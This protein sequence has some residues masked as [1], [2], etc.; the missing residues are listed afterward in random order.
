MPSEDGDVIDVGLPFNFLP[1]HR[2]M[3]R[4]MVDE[5]GDPDEAACRAAMD[6]IFQLWTQTAFDD[7][8]V[9]GWIRDCYS[10][11]EDEHGAVE[12]R[13]MFHDNL[14]NR[15]NSQYVRSQED[16]EEEADD[17]EDDS[18]LDPE[19]CQHVLDSGEQCQNERVEGSDYCHLESHGPDGSE[20][21]S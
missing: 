9:P 21:E 19:L 1:V 5:E 20:G 6:V 10:D 16:A 15:L 18:D 13:Q 12:T 4:E 11:L 2:Q 7:A 3:I 8:E 14:G 17:A